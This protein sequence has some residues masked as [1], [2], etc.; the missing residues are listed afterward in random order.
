MVNDIT[1]IGA[2]I[3]PLADSTLRAMK[4]S[5]LIERIR[6]LEHNY[7]TAVWF[8]ENQAK[9]ICKICANCKSMARGGTP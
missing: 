8:N 5:E 9:N 4:K 3:K 2:Q 7:N 1:T 6:I